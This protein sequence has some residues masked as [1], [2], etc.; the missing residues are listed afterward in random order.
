MILDQSS[1]NKSINVLVVCTGDRKQGPD[2]FVVTVDTAYIAEMSVCKHQVYNISQPSS[3]PFLSDILDSHIS[4]GII[5]RT[6]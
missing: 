3:G 4:L 2:L 1:V 6:T 5:L